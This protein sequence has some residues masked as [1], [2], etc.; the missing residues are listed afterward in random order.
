MVY[1]NNVYQH[2]LKFPNTEH[3]AVTVVIVIVGVTVLLLLLV[4]EVVDS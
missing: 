2:Q 4:V 1:Q 3:E